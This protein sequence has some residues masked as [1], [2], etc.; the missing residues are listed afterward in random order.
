MSNVRINGA[1]RLNVIRQ[2]YSGLYLFA[3]LLDRTISMSSSNT[4]LCAM[5]SVDE[6]NALAL[7][8]RGEVKLLNPLL[9]YHIHIP[10][11]MLY[12]QCLC[13]VVYLCNWKGGDG[14]KTLT[15]VRAI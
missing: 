12:K 7:G 13:N 8:L 4:A 15:P 10:P 11:S 5:V 14:D 1:I 9:E 2:M 6:Y 3:H